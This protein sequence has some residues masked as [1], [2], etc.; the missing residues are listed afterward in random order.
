[1]NEWIDTGLT[2]KV[3]FEKNSSECIETLTRWVDY[4]YTCENFD[5]YQRLVK[6]I[7]I[8]GGTIWTRTE[9]YKIGDLI[10]ANSIDCGYIPPS[11]E[12]RWVESGYTCVG[13][14]KYV[15]E[16]EQ[17]STD[18]S[19][20]WVDTGNNRR[21]VLIEANSIDCGYEPEPGV[22]YRWVSGYTTCVGYDKYELEIEQ[23]S[24]DGGVTWVDTGNNRRRDLIEINSID[25]GYEPPIK[26]C[27]FIVN[28]DAEKVHFF[29][30]DGDLLGTLDVYMGKVKFTSE[31][32]DKVIAV[33]EKSNAFFFP[34]K[35]EIDCDSEITMYSKNIIIAEDNTDGC[36]GGKVKFAIQ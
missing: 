12:Y 21:G 5:K 24:T 36:K 27:S 16:V 4:D 8:D 20:T 26:K 18:G 25:C 33:P 34:C 31:D 1:M 30:T 15:L 28:T 35:K 29:S 14:D 22:E 10:E 19:V 6:E 3:L 23:M 2:R 17:M 9:E 13:Y 11:V 7:S 32:V